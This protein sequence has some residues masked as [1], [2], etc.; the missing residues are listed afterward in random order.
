MG[1]KKVWENNIGGN[2]RVFFISPRVQMKVVAVCFLSQGQ[3]LS[4]E[5][6]SEQ[7]LSAKG[8]IFK[9]WEKE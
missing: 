4:L 1:R 3:K 7:N 9:V 5:I 2:E 8:L 6:K